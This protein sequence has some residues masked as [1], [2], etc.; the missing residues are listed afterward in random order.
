[1]QKVHQ[2]VSN[3]AKHENR[4]ATIKFVLHV[5][6][7]RT[8]NFHFSEHFKDLKKSLMNKYFQLYYLQLITLYFIKVCLITFEVMTIISIN[9]LF[10]ARHFG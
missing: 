7:A 5:Y 2:K 9:K 6:S 10:R 8:C 4:V 3:V 1:M